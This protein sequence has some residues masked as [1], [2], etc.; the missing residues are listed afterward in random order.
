MVKRDKLGKAIALESEH[1]NALAAERTAA[2]LN[3]VMEE[4]RTGDA[5]AQE[6]LDGVHYEAGEY[7]A[8]G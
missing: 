3:D 8:I 5:E 7:K 4:L 1:S 2:R 6:E